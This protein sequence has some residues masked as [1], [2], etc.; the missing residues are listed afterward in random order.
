[1]IGIG[2][3]LILYGIISFIIEASS[4]ESEEFVALYAALYF[5]VVIVLGVE[6]LTVII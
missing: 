6:P 2:I 4:G 1:M 5:I 3:G